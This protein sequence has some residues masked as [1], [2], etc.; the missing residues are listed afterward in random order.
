[1]IH[2]VGPVFSASEDR[3]NLLGSCYR[4]S[5]RVVA[6]LGAG[7]VSFPLVSA[8][9]YRWPPADAIRVA[10]EALGAASGDGFARLVL[11]SEELFDEAN[12]QLSHTA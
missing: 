5:M 9:V 4:E 8:G 3:S 11:W 12:R 1:V 10:I 7:S 2:T 6:E